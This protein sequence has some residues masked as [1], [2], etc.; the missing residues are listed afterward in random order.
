MN[1]EGIFKIGDNYYRNIDIDVLLN[2]NDKMILNKGS[3][4]SSG[5]LSL[6][7]DTNTLSLTVDL[8]G[9]EKWSWTKSS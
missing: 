3:K 4:D 6:G 5:N 8:T 1:E 7:G 2:G 9:N